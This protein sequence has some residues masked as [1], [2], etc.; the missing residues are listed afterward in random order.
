MMGFCRLSF[1]GLEKTRGEWTLVCLSPNLRWLNGAL[2][3]LPITHISRL[4]S[5]IGS[6]QFIDVVGFFRLGEADES[7]V[8]IGLVHQGYVFLPDDVSYPGG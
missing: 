1:R 3:A 5:F 8:G 4:T 2:C 7:L 6:Q